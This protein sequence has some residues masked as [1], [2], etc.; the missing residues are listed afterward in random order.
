MDVSVFRLKACQALEKFVIHCRQ[1]ARQDDVHGK[2]FL[3]GIYAYA[4]EIDIEDFPSDLLVQCVVEDSCFTTPDLVTFK[5]SKMVLLY[6]RMQSQIPDSCVKAIISYWDVEAVKCLLT[7]R[8]I[9]MTKDV[10]RA[11]VMN[12][13]YGSKIMQLLLDKELEEQGLASPDT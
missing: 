13:E 2:L 4:T 5:G 11:A 6:L 3:Q 7:F 12:V 8:N 9:R 10:I 1:A